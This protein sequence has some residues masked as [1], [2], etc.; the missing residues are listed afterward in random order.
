MSLNRAI[1]DARRIIT[2]GGFNVTITL[3][4]PLSVDYTVQGVASRRHLEYDQ[5]GYSINSTLIH[6]TLVEAELI[7]QGIEVRNERGEVSLGKWLLTYT[8][9]TNTERTYS[10]IQTRPSETLGL[11]VCIL[12]R[13][14]VN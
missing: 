1:E 8:D 3:T 6:A 11:I 10:I 14:G 7:A 4:S 9:A 5:E 13:Y 12:Q 2:D